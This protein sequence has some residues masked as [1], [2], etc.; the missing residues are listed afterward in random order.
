MRKAYAQI[1]EIVKHIDGEGDKAIAMTF[2]LGKLVEEI[3]EMAQS[4]NKLN[5]RKK[6]KNETHTE[7]LDNIEEEVADS[8]QCL[9]A[10]AINAGIEYESLKVR[11]VEK[12]GKFENNVNEKMNK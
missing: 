9:M 5:G 8:I 6:I 7:I 11:L 3:G 4:I 1:K 12:N 2:H 10:I